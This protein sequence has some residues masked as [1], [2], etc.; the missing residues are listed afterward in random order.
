MI[1]LLELAPSPRS[2][3]RG[4]Y[5]KS[6]RSMIPT[7]AASTGA[8]FLPSASPAARPSKTMSTFSLTPAPT[9]STASSAVPLGVSSRFSGCTSRSFAPSNLGCFC[10]DTTVPTT[11]AICITD[12]GL[13]RAARSSFNV[14]MV[15]DADDGRVVG[16][17]HRIERKGRF[18][19]SYEEHFF[20]DA[21]ADGIH[22]DERLPRTFSLWRQR[23]HDQQL[24]TRQALLLAGHDEVAN[25]SG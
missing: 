15:H 10:V 24:E 21:G 13:S 4:R 22:R 7:T 18:F 14:P 19:P 20:A 1:H 8:A 25:H 9:L 12:L 17:L 16:R 23:L 6:T 11:R 3:R 5:S 2:H